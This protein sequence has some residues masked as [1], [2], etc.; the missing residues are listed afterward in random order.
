MTAR[1]STGFVLGAL[2]RA[3]DH[4]GRGAFRR[5]GILSRKDSSCWEIWECVL[6]KGP[7]CSEA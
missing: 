1:R 6:G 3:P 7:A 4:I 2:G 5:E